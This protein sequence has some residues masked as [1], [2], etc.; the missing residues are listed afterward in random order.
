[1]ARR[2]EGDF[3]STEFDVGLDE[4]K[5]KCGRGAGDRRTSLDTIPEWPGPSACRA[6][7]VTPWLSLLQPFVMRAS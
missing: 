1:M 5:T 6:H 2:L 4:L 3:D 7:L